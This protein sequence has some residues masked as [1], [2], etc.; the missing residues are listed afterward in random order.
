MYLLLSCHEK[1]NKLNKQ[2]QIFV[3]GCK[4]VGFL[5]PVVRLDILTW[6]SME[7]PQGFPLDS[8]CSIQGYKLCTCRNTKLP[9]KKTYFY[10][11]YHI[12]NG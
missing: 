2:K 10:H 11:F 6:E 9:E 12:N 7:K 5:F 8:S 4:H 3:P 1:E